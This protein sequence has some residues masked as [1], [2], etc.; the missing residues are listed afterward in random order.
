MIREKA[1][2]VLGSE[3]NF[4]ASKGWLQLFMKRK[5]LSLRRRTTVSQK[6]PQDVIRKL[7]DYVMHF[8]KL[9]TTHGFS[10]A[11]IYAMDETACWFDMPS[12]TTIHVRGAKSVPL[13]TTGHEKDHFT[14]ILSAR[15]DGK[16][17]KPFVVFKGKGVRLIKE[18]EKIPG[19]VVKFSVNGW[20]NDGLT[21]DYLH[22]IIGCLSFQKRLL[23]WDAYKCHTSDSIKKEL[24]KMKLHSAVIPGGCTKFIQ[25][26]DVVWNAPFKSNLRRCYDT[27]LSDSSQHQFTKGGNIKAPPRGLLCEWIKEAWNSIPEEM[28]K[29]SFCSCAITTNIDGSD[30][31]KIH[32]FK[33][34]QPCEEG[35]IALLQQMEQLKDE[36]LDNTDPFAS[37]EDEEET[38]ENEACIDSDDDDSPDVSNE[39]DDD[40]SNEEQ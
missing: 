24:R 35:K 31:H 2:D 32:C 36:L 19:V 27:W 8:R 3:A 13:K 18:L 20:M 6:T 37:D 29:N 1:K 33:A 28:I 25:A 10:N 12:E 15:V 16:K 23:V 5:N 4:K 38:L 21:V 9:Q 17:L 11:S 34:G 14:V 30:D 40:S 39:S 7:T 22:S 26:P